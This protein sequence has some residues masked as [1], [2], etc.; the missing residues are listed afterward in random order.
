MR[1]EALIHGFVERRGVDLG[2]GGVAK[3]GRLERVE[4]LLAF[5]V[6]EPAWMGRS[7]DFGLQAIELKVSGI[8]RGTATPMGFQ[9]GRATTA[10]LLPPTG[11]H[12]RIQALTL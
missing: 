1:P 6:G 9:R 5:G 3:A 10:K 4:H 12:R 11:E 7:R 2:W 8:Q